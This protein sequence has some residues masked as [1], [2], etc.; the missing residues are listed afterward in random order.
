MR[1]PKSRLPLYGLLLQSG[2]ARLSDQMAAVVYGWGFLKETGSSAAS[3]MIMASSLAALVGGTFFAGRLIHRFGARNVALTGGWLSVSAASAIAVLYAMDLG[4]PTLIAVI[5]AIGA[6]L[7]GPAG[8]A[9]EVS[10]PQIARVARFDLVKLNALDDGLDSVAGL[11]APGTAALILAA[12]SLLGAMS[13]LVIL[14]LVAILIL[15]FSMPNFR[16]SKNRGSKSIGPAIDFI[17]NDQIIFKLTIL[18][19]IAIALFLTIQ[20]LLIPRAIIVAG[21]Q[22]N[23]L[24]MVLFSAGSGGIAGAL[25]VSRVVNLMGIRYIVALAFFL[26]TLAAGFILGAAAILL[27]C[28]CGALAGLAS[29]IVSAPIATLYQTRPPLHLR[30]DVQ[31]ITGALSLGAAPFA[32]LGVGALAD[33]LALNVLIVGTCASMALLLAITLWWVK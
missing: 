13:S 27:L 31:G 15:T 2:I 10:Y 4:N 3:S 8:V 11:I 6:V 22:E 1:L 16:G 9:S 20:L 25:L 21:H 28:V 30:A 5:A 32:I 29:G 23:V 14:G 33:F 26:L 7:D 18:F 12:F 17:W 19:S 24:A